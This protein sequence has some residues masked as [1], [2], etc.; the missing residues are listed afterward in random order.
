MLALYRPVA[1]PAFVSE[2]WPRHFV[3]GTFRALN[4]KSN[5]PHCLWTR[6]RVRANPSHLLGN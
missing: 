6:G 4:V 1:V 2:E 5:F 3:A